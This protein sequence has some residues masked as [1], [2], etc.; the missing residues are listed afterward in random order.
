L[1]GFLFPR[2]L[3]ERETPSTVGPQDPKFF[4]FLFRGYL[5]LVHPP[6]PL[7]VSFPIGFGVFT[8]A[9]LS[10]LRTFLLFFSKRIGVPN[11]TW[12]FLRCFPVFD[13]PPTLF[14]FSWIFPSPAGLMHEWGSPLPQ[15][16]K[17]FF[18]PETSSWPN[19]LAVFLP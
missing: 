7:L 2:R 9:P 13:P 1:S 10:G 14:F 11:G 4:P 8:S 19:G 15:P 5:P 12:S 16:P 17:P 18:F 6:L 3:G